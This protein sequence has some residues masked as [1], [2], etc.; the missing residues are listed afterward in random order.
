MTLGR[1]SA[2]WIASAL[3]VTL[4]LVAR[5]WGDYPTNDDWQYAR[6]TKRLAETG[7]FQVD[8][9]IAPSLV[10]QA[11]AAATV[12]RVFGFSHTRLRLLT[13]AF[14]LVLLHLVDGLLATAALAWRSRVVALAALAVNPLFV[15][16]SLSFM[17]EVYGY[18]PALL[19]AWIW[20]RYRPQGD[21]GR[22]RAWTVLAAGAL[23]GASFWIR[24]YAVL[25]LPALWVG[26][27]AGSRSPWRHR[28]RTLV[29][30]CALSLAGALPFVAGYF[31]WAQQSD[32]LRPEFAQPLA[33]LVHLNLRAWAAE[34]GP[35]VLFLGLSCAPIVVFALAGRRRVTPKELMSGVIVAGACLASAALFQSMVDASRQLDFYMGHHSS[36]P[37]VGNTFSRAGIGAVTLTDVY[38]LGAPARPQWASWVWVTVVAL[39]VVSTALAGLLH[40][41]R[42]A[43]IP[44]ESDS[45]RALGGFGAALALL[46]FGVSVQAYGTL[47][48]DRYYFPAVL[49]TIL[50]AAGRRL[51]GVSEKDA[52]GPS[53]ASWCAAAAVVV[54]AIVTTCGVHNYFRW[55]DARWSLYERVLASGADPR[56]VDGGYE[57][58]GWRTL[59]LLTPGAEMRCIGSCSCTQGWYCADNSYLLA[60]NPVPGYRVVEEMQP[61]YWLAEGPPVRVLQRV[62]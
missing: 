8:V 21:A 6:V 52:G 15:N 50:V 4:T 9:P 18:V 36:F 25:A 20:L 22:V 19:G 46:S 60:M 16:L 5:P 57:I 48:F 47:M 12:V 42:H 7:T 54:L 49:G 45:R 13:L 14:A 27:Y 30:P 34:S 61:A 26:A 44:A 38:W 53:R 62:E 32:A 33:R 59:D 51:P 28:L 10:G 40:K 35:F 29:R 41:E 23:C 37:F 58:Q 55:N 2:A 43:A 56:T 39:A 1:S 17:T 3:L 11:Y 31:V 24:Q